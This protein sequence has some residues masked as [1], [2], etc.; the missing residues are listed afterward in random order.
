[1]CCVNVEII[2][3][4]FKSALN[5]VKRVLEE[6]HQVTVQIEYFAVDDDDD[7][8]DDTGTADTLRMMQDKIKVSF[9][10]DTNFV[11]L[12][13]ALYLFFNVIQAVFVCLHHIFVEVIITQTPQLVSSIVKFS[14]YLFSNVDYIL[15]S[16]N[17][18]DRKCYELVVKVVAKP[19]FVTADALVGHSGQSG[20]SE[21][22]PHYRWVITSLSP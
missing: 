6:L 8:A 20:D 14:S 9:V 16:L 13:F 5:D 12:F 17:L 4:V 21:K 7:D 3:A 22:A 19:D 15:K 11:T 18:G 1:M 10:D 2:V